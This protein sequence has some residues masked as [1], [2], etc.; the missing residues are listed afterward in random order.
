MT[1]Y[2]FKILIQDVFTFFDSVTIMGM[3][4][5][6]WIIIVLVFSAIA[7]FVRGNK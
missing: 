2:D 4:I 3:S 1:T 6:T 7:I 5:T